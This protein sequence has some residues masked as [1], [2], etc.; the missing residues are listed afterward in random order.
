M[1][2]VWI[3][4]S[5][6]ELNGEVLDAVLVKGKE[7]VQ[8]WTAHDSPLKATFEVFSNRFIVV[9][10][11]ESQYNASGCSI[12]K[13]LRFIKQVETDFNLQL[14][15]RLLVP[16]KDGERVEVVHSSKIKELLNSKKI[17]ENTIVFNTASSNSLEFEGWEQSLKDTWLKKYL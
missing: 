12:D 4:L 5:D 7:F 10:V 13:L 16:F 3:Y 8:S 2:K 15:N 14:L 1:E 11:D 6:K 17:D 9:K